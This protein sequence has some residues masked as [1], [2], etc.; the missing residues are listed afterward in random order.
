MEKY[1]VADA[2]LKGN[3]T[4]FMENGN[5]QALRYLDHLEGRL[6]Y[7]LQVMNGDAYLKKARKMLRDRRHEL[8]YDENYTPFYH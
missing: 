5:P 4:E 6:M 7:V 1:G 3:R 2:I 8:P